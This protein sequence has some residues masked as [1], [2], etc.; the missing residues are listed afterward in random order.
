MLST[1]YFTTELGVTHGDSKFEV[2]RPLSRPMVLF[3]VITGVPVAALH[4]AADDAETFITERRVVASAKSS[5]LGVV[6]TDKKRIALV[7]T[8]LLFDGYI[9]FTITHG[10]EGGGPLLNEINVVREGL[11]VRI[12]GDFSNGNRRL[13]LDAQEDG[14]GVSVTQDEARDGGPK[15]A[16]FSIAVYPPKGM[17]FVGATWKCVDLI[18][19]KIVTQVTRSMAPCQFYAAG[20]C[21]DGFNCMFSHN[22]PVMGWGAASEP[23]GSGDFTFV[24][25]MRHRPGDD[26]RI[27]GGFGASNG[28]HQS[29]SDG[30]FGARQ[31]G[32]GSS[33]GGWGGFGGTNSTGG[34]GGFGASSTSSGG[35]GASSSRPEPIPL[36]GFAFGATPVATGAALAVPPP[37]PSYTPTTPPRGAFD[38]SAP[39]RQPTPHGAPRS[40]SYGPPSPP[41]WADMP[42]QMSLPEDNAHAAN[43]RLG[44]DVVNNHAEELSDD[45]VDTTKGAT[46]VVLCLSVMPADRVEKMKPMNAGDALHRAM[47]LAHDTIINE[48]KRMLASLVPIVYKAEEEC[49][50]CLEG[51]P[52]NIYARCGHQCAHDA[53]TRAM[54]PPIK[55]PVCRAP[56][57]AI[58]HE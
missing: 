48:N 40:P 22:A 8:N 31:G 42:A 15:G 55:C 51:K 7:V 58:L 10:R 37:S 43:I 24:S 56:V 11:S 53:C 5:F 20:N 36:Q 1:K 4:F 12:E 13:H 47:E 38:F 44:T 35:W 25:S 39:P 26:T 16:Y 41:S 6:D 34:G 2:V 3:N 57:E 49:V 14:N 45:L 9:H 23:L 50:I 54:P 19:R 29:G 18:C 28:P 32:F 21:R 30:G 33:G 52:E 17:S 46:Y 27:G